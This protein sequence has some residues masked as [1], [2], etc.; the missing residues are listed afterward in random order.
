MCHQTIL[1]PKK[2]VDLGRSHKQLSYKQEV[3]PFINPQS[4][5]DVKPQV[6][7]ALR[8]KPFSPYPTLSKRLAG[9]ADGCATA[10]LP[11][12]VIPCHSSCMLSIA[13]ISGAP[14]VPPP[15][16]LGSSTLESC[17]VESMWPPSYTADCTRSNCFCSGFLKPPR[18]LA[19]FASLPSI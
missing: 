18:A 10:S 15:S 7:S 19:P 5:E 4:Q 11:T 12:S 6:P 3:Y 16:S 17:Q 2:T 8:W 1:C 14:M 13:S 9:H